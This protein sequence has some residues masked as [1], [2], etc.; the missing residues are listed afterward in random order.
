MPGTITELPAGMNINNNVI[1]FNQGIIEN[2]TNEAIDMS[3]IANTTLFGN[4]QGKTAKILAPM[5]LEITS[6]SDEEYGDGCTPTEAECLGGNEFTLTLDRHIDKKVKYAACQVQDLGGDVV[7]QQLANYIRAWRVAQVK[8]TIAHY[9]SQLTPFVAD[10]TAVPNN[11]KE[12]IEDMLLE[13]E[14]KGYR[15][16]SLTVLVSA[17]TKSLLNKL[18]M[19]CCELTGTSRIQNLS[20]DFGVDA[21][22]NGINLLPENTDIMIYPKGYAMFAESCTRLPQIKQGVAISEEDFVFITGRTDFGYGG[23]K[24]DDGLKV[25]D[26]ASFLV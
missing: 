20:N 21:V 22:V 14:M 7:G 8:E 25:V 18:N 10:A 1:T 9:D 24:L 11:A 26:I 3:L 13:M 4:I 17:K 15:R 6:M 5:N 2:I 16:D 12:L 23:Y 19:S